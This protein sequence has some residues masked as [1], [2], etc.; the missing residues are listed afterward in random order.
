MND[1]QGNFEIIDTVGYDLIDYFILTEDAW[2][3][4]YYSPLE[5]KIQELIPEYKD[6]TDAQELFKSLELEIDMYRKFS[7]Y[8]G[9]VFYIISPTIP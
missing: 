7:D 3:D 2:W 6:N 5:Q 1:I 9:Y 8:Y 4:D